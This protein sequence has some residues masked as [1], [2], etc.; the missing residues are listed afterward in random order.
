MVFHRV[1]LVGL[2]AA[3]LA[4]SGCIFSPKKDPPVNNLPTYSADLTHPDSLIND[5]MAAYVR[6]EIE[7][8]A[9][10]IG[11]DFKF[12][13]QEADLTPE[14]PLGYWNAEEES[15]GTRRLFEDI[16]VENI[17]IDLTWLAPE[18]V[19]IEGLQA[20]RVIVNN[21]FLDVDQSN[22]VTLR[23]DGDQQ[24]FYFRK[25]NPDFGQDTTRYYMVRWEDLGNPGGVG[26]PGKGPRG[27]RSDV[28]DG[29]R[30]EY[31]TLSDLRGRLAQR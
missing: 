7:P 3:L 31:V 4:A 12:I 18:T 23:V 21:T 28:A 9:R 20:E 29:R 11:Q 25:G 14:I 2:S 13:F 6:Q 17:K 5:L 8:Y 19:I 10:L 27:T 26:A 16:T 1:L 24:F 15:T 22:G 30:V